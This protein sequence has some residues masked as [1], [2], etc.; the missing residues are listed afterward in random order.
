MYQVRGL[1]LHS[2]RMW[3]WDS[4]RRAV[5]FMV[6]A[7]MNALIFHEINI[8]DHLQPQAGGVS[9]SLS[10][11]YGIRYTY[12]HESSEN[13]IAYI[14]RV[15]ELAH[16]NGIRFYFEV[17]EPSYPEELLRVHRELFSPEGQVC[18]THP[19]WFEF[20]EKKIERLLETVPDF[21][22]IIESAC[23]AETKVSLMPL[24]ERAD[25]IF[26]STDTPI[27]YCTCERCRGTKLS[28]WNTNI[29]MSLY[30]P[31]KKKGKQL[32]I[33]DFTYSP[34]SQ[35][36][37]LESVETPKDVII[38]LKNVPHD[39]YPTFPLNPRIGE[40]GDYDQWLEFDAWG[41]FFGLGV[42]P[43]I[44]LDD[45]RDR[46]T[47]AQERDNR[48]KGYICRADWEL[49]S[50]GWAMDSLNLINLYGLAKQG[51]EIDY[52][53]DDI[54]EYVL[55][56]L[57]KG[58]IPFLGKP[59][60]VENRGELATIADLLLKTWPI[61]RG[62]LYIKDHVFQDNSLVL[63]SFELIRHMRTNLHPLPPWDPSRPDPLQNLDTSSLED[64][65]EEKARALREVRAIVGSLRQETLTLN[66][67]INMSLLS[68]FEAFELYIEGFYHAGEAYLLTEYALL[69]KCAEDI[70]K[71]CQSAESLPV[72]AAKL[73]KHV[74]KYLYEP[75][76]H[77]IS[78]LLDPQRFSRLH[79]SLLDALG[80]VSA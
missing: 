25:K 28:E 6:K 41:Q 2:S 36:A 18:P 22:G 33:R 54:F 32:V 61:I 48:V 52:R 56:L 76:S 62:S 47:H 34:E 65:I 59:I 5:D 35:N 53:Y 79:D 15:I 27:T 64:L 46:L 49:I 45:M 71:A 24:K 31:L 74:V 9:T 63:D 44:L 70:K 26:P 20:L 57:E 67:E 3:S 55:S 16:S 66:I 21:D 37:F 50:E 10:R 19:F 23:T 69:T 17:K 78:I 1:E 42:F 43:C 4:V 8:I 30:R 75:Q 51:K 68:L 77:V 14:N 40:V 13:N 11:S 12:R 7:E 73:K 80:C 38:C 39:F 58:S 29:T 60:K 72:H